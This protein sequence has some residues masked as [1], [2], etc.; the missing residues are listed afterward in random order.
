M[1]KAATAKYVTSGETG[2]SEEYPKVKEVLK[3]LNDIR[4]SLESITK[5]VD[6]MSKINEPKREWFWRRR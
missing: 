1:G 3:T 5:K 4:L 2:N 6:S